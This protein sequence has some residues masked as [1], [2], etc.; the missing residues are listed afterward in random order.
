[1]K[2][3][4]GGVK[5]FSAW[6]FGDEAWPDLPILPRGWLTFDMCNLTCWPS[7]GPSRPANAPRYS[8]SA[9]R[10]TPHRNIFWGKNNTIYGIMGTCG[11]SETMCGVLRFGYW[12]CTRVVYSNRVTHGKWEIEKE[13]NRREK[14]RE[15]RERTLWIEGWDQGGW[16]G[17]LRLRG[18]NNAPDVQFES[19]DIFDSSTSRIWIRK[20]QTISVNYIIFFTHFYLSMMYH[21]RF[22]YIFF[23]LP[24]ALLTATSGP[25]RRE[26]NQCR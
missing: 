18:L 12:R 26:K 21:V 22:L 25:E 17:G 7:I 8:Q 10:Y 6:S 9:R 13:K 5:V 1:M 16:E 4:E 11:G 23:S 19:I 14:R 20:G 15:R 24:F 3:I 2:G